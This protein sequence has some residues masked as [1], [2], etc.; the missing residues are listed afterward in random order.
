MA[1]FI[2]A[3]IRGVLLMFQYLFDGLTG[4]KWIKWLE[5]KGGDVIDGIV[6]GT[7][8]AWASAK[9]TIKKFFTDD[10]P[11]AIEGAWDTLVE[12]GKDIVN[13][14]LEGI[15][16][17]KDAAIDGLEGL[18]EDL[19]DYFNGT[20]GI[21]SPSKK[22][23]KSGKYIV[24]GVEKG[25]E[26]ETPKLNDTVSK[27]AQGSLDTWKDEWGTHS[28]SDE[29]YAMSKELIDGGVSGLEDYGGDLSAMTGDTAEDALNAFGDKFS[30]I[31]DVMD[32][33]LADLST[34][35]E[36]HTDIDILPNI[37]IDEGHVERQLSDLGYGGHLLNKVFKTET[38]DVLDFSQFTATSTALS[39]RNAELEAQ[40]HADSEQNNLM[41]QTLNDTISKLTDSFENGII[42]IPDNATFTVP[43]NVDGQT[44]ANVA[45]PYLD[46]ISGEK[47]NLER[48]GVTSR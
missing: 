46:V 10:L 25:I 2:G 44:I 8:V 23:A 12:V 45:A 28:E 13:A 27:T 33:N 37:N 26:K 43:V 40:R 7:K 47:M 9:E 20:L 11:A 41:L 1:Y 32:T 6:E 48:A 15:K 17:A 29:T 4:G 35:R 19:Y 39:D 18:G 34:K 14:I 3:L 31:G 24:Q 16:S 36:V 42:N 22:F 5:E 38:D 30:G 21:E